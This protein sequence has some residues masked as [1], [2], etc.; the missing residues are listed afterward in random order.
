MKEDK[1]FKNL[2]RNK[3]INKDDVK[4]NILNSRRSRE[5]SNTAKFFTKRRLVP[6]A[7][8]FVLIVMAFVP[9]ASIYTEGQ[10]SSNY[11]FAQTTAEYDDIYSVINDFKDTEKNTENAFN[12]RS[13][14]ENITD[15]INTVFQSESMSGSIMDTSYSETN[16]QTEGL[17]EGDIVKTDGQYIYKLND[18]GCFIISANSGQLEVTTSILIENYVPKELYIS[19]DTLIIIGGLYDNSYQP[20]FSVQPLVECLSY[21]S[22]SK[23]DIRVYDITEKDSPVLDRQIELDGNFYTSRLKLEDNKLFF[24]VNYHF[25]NTY[26]ENA[27]IPKIKD[28]AL[29][30]GEQTLMPAENLYYYDDLVNYNYLI[31]GEI[32]LDEPDTSSKITA[33]LGL[34]GQIYVSSE[35][36]YVSTYDHQSIYLRNILGW[37]RESEVAGRTRIVKIALDTLTQ[38]AVGNVEGAINDRYWLDEYDGHL[39]VATHSSV[40]GGESYNNVFVLDEDLNTVGE[41]KNIAPDETIYSV[42][43]NE[44]TGSLV[45]FKIIDPYFNLDLSDPTNPLISTG[46]KEDGVS[47]YIHYIENTDYTIGI[48]KMS[49]VVQTSWG[50]RVVWTGLKVSLYNNS[51][52]EAVNVNTV[53]L[54]GSCWAE[55]FYNPKALLYDAENG[56]FAFGYEN[57]QYDNNYSYNSMQQGLAVFSFDVEEALD[58]DK[59]TYEGTLTNLTEIDPYDSGYYYNYH[60]FVERGITIDDYIY[61]ISHNYVKSYTISDLTETDTV[62]LYEITP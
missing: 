17:D 59:L 37:V 14:S 19:G 6:I 30:D 47:Y 35:N 9:A 21:Y 29:N 36:I 27:F 13:F 51:S 22:C 55:L 57:W 4:N 28:T 52:G 10:S 38:T 48:G 5:P 20:Y 58:E 39:R 40:W 41:I 24:M 34:G 7:L 45:T 16:V 56:L 33:H 32:D 11:S 60:S 61:T 43:F 42:R 1:F 62:D 44:E 31:F 46:L 15:G 25:Y 3:L 54:E 18:K 49:E 23:T 2:M 8:A 50:E 26:D 12:F 53:V